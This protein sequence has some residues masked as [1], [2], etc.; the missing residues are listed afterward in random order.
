MLAVALALSLQAS[1][2]RVSSV[3]G[4]LRIHPKFASEPL[5]N[6][7]TL[8]VWLPPG[9]EKEGR[10]R[11]PVT[12]LHDGQNVF[13][14]MTSFIPNQEW[15][16]DETATALIG[17]GLLPPMIV[18]G[19]DNAGASRGDEYLPTRRGYG[20]K[21]DAYGEFLMKEVMP[22][23]DRTYRTRRGARDTALVG[24]SF[25]GVITSY[26]GLR[27][28]EA[29][30]RLGICSPSVWWDSRVLLRLVSEA[31]KKTGQRLWIDI[32]TKEGTK[33]VTDAQDL[34]KA[35]EA[36]GWRSGR[37]LALIVEDGKEH[38]EA[39]WAG[40]FDTMMIFLWK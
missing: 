14:G 24:S 18:V 39:A 35:Y 6:E 4:D 33:A 30:G 7:R 23:I 22:F 40:R 38:N 8:R 19:I 21:A 20:G 5:G 17:A 31:P 15:R 34:A 26:L 28:P 29:F 27:H 10:R 36:K 3:T 11:Y 2:G 9:Y 1:D 37:D 12:Y 32:G 13:D 25:G 16:A